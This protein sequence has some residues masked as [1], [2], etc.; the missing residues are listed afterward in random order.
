MNIKVV[1]Q[2]SKGISLVWFTILA[3]FTIEMF[4]L[5]LGF[6]G[7][8]LRLSVV[9]MAGLAGLATPA[10]KILKKIKELL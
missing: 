2:P 6:N 7:G 8:I 4:A 9:T 5:M 1:S 3:I 10:P